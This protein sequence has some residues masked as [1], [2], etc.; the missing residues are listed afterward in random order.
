GGA[1]AAEGEEA[2]VERSFLGRWHADRSLGLDEER[3]AERRLWRD[4]GARRRAQCRSGLPWPETLER[5]PCFDHRSR[6]QALP[7]GETPG[8]DAVLTRA[9]ASGKTH[10]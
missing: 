3:Q 7:Q 9:S 6:C 5:H 1:G 8:D 4:A 2:S 10:T